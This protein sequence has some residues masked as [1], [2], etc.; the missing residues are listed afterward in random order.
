[1][2]F[3]KRG[4]LL[5]VMAVLF[6][7]AVLSGCLGYTSYRGEFA[8][9]LAGLSVE[10]FENKTLYSGLEFD[11]TR[12]VQEEVT[13]RTGAPLAERSAARV[14]LSGRLTQF[15]P[16]EALTIGRGDTVLDRQA[17][18]AASVTLRGADGQVLY[19]S[20]GIS[21]SVTYSASGGSEEVARQDVMKE[22]ARR[23]VFALLDRW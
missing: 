18:A 4:T 11:L 16:R 3:S 9:Q 2:F 1:M 5:R 19:E 22:L 10:V 7:S 8:A 15:S 12:A 17:V 23:I 14:V 20:A 21:A 6:S 13:R